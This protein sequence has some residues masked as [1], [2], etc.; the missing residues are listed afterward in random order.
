MRPGPKWSQAS[1][2]S[3][4]IIYSG[5]LT[6]AIANDITATLSSGSIPVHGPF[7]HKGAITRLHGHRDFE[8]VI[9]VPIVVK[10]LQDGCHHVHGVATMPKHRD[11][12]GVDR[13][14]RIGDG[15]GDR[16]VVGSG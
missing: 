3:N 9:A 10:M 6:P 8:T 12:E 7:H 1:P 14:H 16:F 11:G 4:I 2:I 5:F 13:A 15:R